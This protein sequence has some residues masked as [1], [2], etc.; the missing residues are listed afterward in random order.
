LV[1]C[2]AFFG[3][4]EIGL[5]VGIYTVLQRRKLE[6]PWETVRSGISVSV[7]DWAARRTAGLER[8]E[9]A[10]KPDLLVPVPDVEEAESLAPLL[11]ALTRQNGSVKL[12]G[13]RSTD[14][15][16][17]GLSRVVEGLQRRGIYASGTIVEGEDFVR[18]TQV[19]MDVM[20]AAFFPPNLVVIDASRHGDAEL[21]P[22]IDR[23]KE[24]KL[25]VVVFLPHP[26][27]GLGNGRE[28]ATWLSDRSPEWQLKLHNA[29]LD[30]VALAAYLLSRNGGRLRMST[31]VRDSHQRDAAKLWLQ[32]LVEMGRLGAATS[33]EV[34]DGDFISA[35]SSSAEADVHVLG[36]S[37]IIE[38]QRLQEIRDAAGGACVFLLD[39][40]YES[41]LS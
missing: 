29:N 23:C 32:R 11:A 15:L 18:D 27:G 7:A 19:A 36:L 14:R 33:T 34:F 2:S 25:G 5:V 9:R 1:L 8:T 12:V 26:D 31:V 40:G 3:I 24:R 41:V 30:L 28:I 16:R 20:A 10:W 21:Q 22:I 13:L 17:D 39:S 37:Q 4:F 35:I 38:V 6:T